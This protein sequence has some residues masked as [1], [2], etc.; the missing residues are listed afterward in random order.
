MENDK[1][2]I[3]CTNEAV[4]ELTAKKCKQLFVVLILHC[5][6]NDKEEFVD[7]YLDGLKE[8]F[9]YQF[10]ERS[11][12]EKYDEEYSRNKLICDLSNQVTTAGSS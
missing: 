9:V 3:N 4:D 5:G 8:E 6:V 12:E 2:W 1:I 7:H 10:N 11:F